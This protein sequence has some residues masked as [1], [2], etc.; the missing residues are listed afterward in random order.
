MCVC[1]CVI[2]QP[3]AAVLQEVAQVVKHSLLVLTAD[4]TEVAQKATTAGHHLG[5]SNLLRVKNSIQFTSAHMEI[6][7]FTLQINLSSFLH[8]CPHAV[9]KCV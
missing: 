7:S 3:H 6:I 5:E 1:V 8:A 2:T 4:T 9:A